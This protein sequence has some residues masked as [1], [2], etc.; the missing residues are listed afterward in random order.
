MKKIKV[1]P[2]NGLKINQYSPL[3]LTLLQ[4]DWNTAIDRYGIGVFSDGSVLIY[5]TL[6]IVGSYAPPWSQFSGN[7]LV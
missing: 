3:P 6:Q 1:L 7:N 2:S 5:K 4:T